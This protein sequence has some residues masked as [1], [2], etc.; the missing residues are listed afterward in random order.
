[1][2][3]IDPEQHR[4]HVIMVFVGYFLIGLAVLIATIILLYLVFGFAYK[5]GE[6]VQNGLIFVSSTPHPA[7]I[8][9]DGQLDKHQTNSR[10]NLQEGRY[11]LMLKRDDYRPW[12]RDIQI[13]GGKV[14]HFDYPFLFP[15]TLASSDIKS[16]TVAPE[17]AASSLDK[18]W[19]LVGTAGTVNTFELFDTKDPKAV[20]NSTITLPQTLL[21]PYAGKQT[22]QYVEWANDNKH[23]ILKHVFGNNYEYV[24][25]DRTAPASSVNLTKA[26]GVNPSE[27]HLINRKYDQYYLYNTK[28]QVISKATLG[29]PKPVTYLD[30][31]LAYKSY[32]DDTMLYAAAAGPDGDGMVKLKLQQGNKT[33]ALTSFPAGTHYVVQLAKYDGDM[34]VVAGAAKTNRVY[35]YKNPVAQLTNQKAPKAVPVSVLEVPS[36]DFVSFSDN[37]RFIMAEHGTNFAVY[38]V[39]DEQD[40]AY[41][42]PADPL[43]RPQKHATWMDGN[44][45]MYVSQGSVVVFDYDNNN[46]QTLVAAR[47]AYEP[48]FDSSYR[49]LYAFMPAKDNAK[50]TVLAATPL[51]TPADQ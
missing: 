37:A 51:L 16:Y 40:F 36:P 44:R 8:Y 49:T 26:F 20:T 24:L 3:F 43:D 32:S 12:Q 42:A 10:F 7:N 15:V 31:V 22:W 1:M 27:L 28:T 19:L 48:A 46:R 47:P 35:I 9:L 45:L 17:F 41:N 39:E 18:R 34:Y 6:V 23:V 13:T 21:T 38:D 2:D 30:H 33:Y 11:N 4:K 25:L 29:Q 50:Q 14:V 5:K